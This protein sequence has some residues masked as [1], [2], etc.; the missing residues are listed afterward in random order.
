MC[1]RTEAPCGGLF[2]SFTAT[3]SGVTACRAAIVTNRRN[4]LSSPPPSLLF[5]SAGPRRVSPRP[6]RCLVCQILPPNERKPLPRREGRWCCPCWRRRGLK[7]LSRLSVELPEDAFDRLCRQHL[8]LS[9]RLAAVICCS[10]EMRA[11]MLS[12]LTVVPP[13][14]GGRERV[15]R[16]PDRDRCL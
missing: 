14:E 12:A 13:W 2:F 8:S 9:W 15:P 11:G 5:P 4:T 10:L 1:R 3:T 6:C 16:H 7:T